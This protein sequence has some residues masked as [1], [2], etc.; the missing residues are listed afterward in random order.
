MPLA[1]ICAGG[2][3]N[4]GRPYRDRA[5]PSTP[6]LKSTRRHTQEAEDGS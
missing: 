2:G 1:G 4:K 3:P 5:L 6:G